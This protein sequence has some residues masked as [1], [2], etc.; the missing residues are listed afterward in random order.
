MDKFI[1]KEGKEGRK[2][3]RNERDRH[4]DKT[5]KQAQRRRE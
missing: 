2:S 5:R 4:K 3:E 1:S